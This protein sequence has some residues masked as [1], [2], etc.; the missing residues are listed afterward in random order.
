VVNEANS[1]A[2]KVLRLQAAKVM[3]W[4]WMN[5]KLPWA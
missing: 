5:F 4:K 2:F 1:T 3:R